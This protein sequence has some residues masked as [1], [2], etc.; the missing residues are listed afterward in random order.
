MMAAMKRQGDGM[1]SQLSIACA[2]FAGPDMDNYVVC[3]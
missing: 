1:A 2:K 3:E